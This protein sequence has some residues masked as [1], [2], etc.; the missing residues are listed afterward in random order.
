MENPDFD[1]ILDE[2]NEFHLLHD[3]VS[4]FRSI[5]SENEFNFNEENDV[6]SARRYEENE[7]TISLLIDYEDDNFT[8]MGRNIFTD[9]QHI[10]RDAENDFPMNNFSGCV[11][12]T[13]SPTDYSSTTIHMITFQQSHDE[14]D[15]G[16]AARVKASS[17]EFSHNSNYSQNKANKTQFESNN[18]KEIKFPLT[19]YIPL[20]TQVI[21]FQQQHEPRS[22]YLL[23]SLKLWQ[24]FSNSGD[25]EKL[26]VLLND[27]LDDKCVMINGPSPPVVGRDTIYALVVSLLRNIPDF[28][29]FYTNIVRS[30]KRV[31]T[32]TSNN[33]GSFPY[34]NANGETKLTWNF[35]EIT[36]IDK[37]DD[38]HKIQKQKYDML[39]CQNKIIKFERSVTRFLLLNRDE[40][41]FIKIMSCD[42][43]INVY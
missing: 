16:E 37:M 20:P 35:F 6:E 33:F 22:R 23:R 12:D 17:V 14:I 30:K 10:A 43:K 5:N 8:D 24:E 42:D 19:R 32:M 18:S 3:Y 36:P 1:D 9:H 25:L 31:I 4:D 27:I 11:D 29:V 39:K 41:R 38:H 15:I 7:D 40:K 34:A 13:S 2:V 21:T 26:R 28:C